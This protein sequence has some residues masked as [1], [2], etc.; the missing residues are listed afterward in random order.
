M[1]VRFAP[2]PTGHLHVGNARTA[3]FNWLLARGQGGTFILRVEDT[4]LERSTRESEAT[5]WKTCGGWG[6]TG[7]RVSRR[8]ATSGRIGSRALRD[9]SRRMPITLLAVGHALLLLLF[10]R[11]ARGRA[12]GAARGGAAAEV[13]GHLPRHRRR[14]R[15]RARQAAR[16]ARRHPAAGARRSRGRFQ[17]MVRGTVTFHTDVIG[18]PVLVRSDGIPAY[19]Y[20]VVIDDQLMAVTHVIRGEDHISN[21]PRQVLLYEAFGWTPPAL[22][23]PL[24]GAG[25]RSRTAVE[26]ARRD[27]GRRVPRQGLPAR[28]AGELPG[29]DR[30]VAAEFEVQGAECNAARRDPGRG[31]AAR[32]ELARRFRLEDVSHSAGVFDEDKLAWVNRHYLKTHPA[33]LGWSTRR[34]RSCASGHRRRRSRPMPRGTGW[35]R[36]CRRPRH[37]SIASSEL[38]ERLRTAS[39]TSMPLRCSP[40]RR[41]R[42]RAEEPGPTRS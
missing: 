21:T 20:A 24:A 17:D 29:A 35:R 42:A 7:T 14:G 30:L 33:R 34:C 36:P 16:R 26:A 15:A 1:R 27:V 28:G 31:T 8:A 9:L 22:R 41:T 19:N 2:S 3:L 23:P 12:Q 18:D 6:C 11:E 40:A 5:S 39:S 4:D 32:L 13:R 37:R 25:S 38:P 10:G